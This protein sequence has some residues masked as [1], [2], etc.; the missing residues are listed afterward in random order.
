M[1]VTRDLRDETHVCVV[2]TSVERVP[3]NGALGIG[4]SCTSCLEMHALE[5]G[6]MVMPLS[7]SVPHLQYLISGSEV[8]RG[9][10]LTY[11]LCP[12]PPA[13]VSASASTRPWLLPFLLYIY[14]TV[15]VLCPRDGS[16]DGRN[17]HAR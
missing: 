5:N 14:V 10:K 15:D 1:S 9:K 16:S 4:D 8:F 6:G 17:Y 12:I 3:R 11:L 7:T 13:M 2:C